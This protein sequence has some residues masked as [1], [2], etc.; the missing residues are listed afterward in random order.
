[1]SNDS[2]IVAKEDRLGGVY[3]RSHLFRV[4]EVSPE[5]VV[6]ACRGLLRV[7]GHGFDKHLQR[8]LQ[9]HI[10]AAIVIIIIAAQVQ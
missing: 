2:R 3:T 6:N 10:H 4:S 1:M 8:A 9:Q 5:R 7:T